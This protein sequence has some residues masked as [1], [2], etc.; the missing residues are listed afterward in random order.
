M[1]KKLF[2]AEMEMS[3]SG[4]ILAGNGKGGVPIT[5]RIAPRIIFMYKGYFLPNMC[6]SFTLG[7]MELFHIIAI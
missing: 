6:R 5:K 1:Q 4:M 7:L 2:N 3:K